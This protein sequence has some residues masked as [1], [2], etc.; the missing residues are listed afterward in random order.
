MVL[1]GVAM[2]L[3]GVRV[4]VGFPERRFVSYGPMH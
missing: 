3:L 4:M 2:Q 1:A